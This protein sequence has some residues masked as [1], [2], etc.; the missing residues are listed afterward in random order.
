MDT[1]QDRLLKL[2]ERQVI[3]VERI[4]QILEQSLPRQPAPNHRAILEDFHQ[5]DW[6]SI[7]AKVELE[8]K[9][10][11]ASVIW[12]GERYKRRSPNRDRQ[13]R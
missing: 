4:A 12:N 3:A 1:N 7:G 11:V 13:F 5:F 8:D 6:S 9:Y 2:Q 10:G